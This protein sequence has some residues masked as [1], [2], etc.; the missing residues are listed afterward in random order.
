MKAY[1]AA[2]CYGQNFYYNQLILSCFS[3][4]FADL[5]NGSVDEISNFVHYF[6]AETD[7]TKAARLQPL[8]D[9]GPILDT[10]GTCT[11][12]EAQK[13]FS[14]LLVQIPPCRRYSKVDL[15]KTIMLT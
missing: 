12:A 1:N 6:C 4:L 13:S 3:L 14:S 8:N 7:A 2:S 5:K 11:Y 15:S 9:L 10:I